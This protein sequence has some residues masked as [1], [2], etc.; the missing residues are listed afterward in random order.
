MAVARNGRV[1][2][3]RARANGRASSEDEET[4]DMKALAFGE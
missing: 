3:M 4:Q 1:L 2:E